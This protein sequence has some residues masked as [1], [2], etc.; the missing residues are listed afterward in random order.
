MRCRDPKQVVEFV[1]QNYYD[2]GVAHSFFTDG[3][4]KLVL[5]LLSSS[6]LAFMI[7][8]A[9]ALAHRYY[10]TDGFFYHMRAYGR[11]A[12]NREADAE[13]DKLTRNRIYERSGMALG[14]SVSFCCLATLLLVVAIF[15]GAASFGD[16]G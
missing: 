3:I 9:F 12:A 6:S 1:R 2:A 5:L 4:A 11:K 15:I 14:V 16:G 7:T 13:A 8:A 10:S